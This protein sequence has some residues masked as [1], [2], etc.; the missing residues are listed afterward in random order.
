VK[1]VVND[2]YKNSKK[3]TVKIYNLCKYMKKVEE[4]NGDEIIT[5]VILRLRN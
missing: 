3:T 2:I 1:F 5:E 4:N